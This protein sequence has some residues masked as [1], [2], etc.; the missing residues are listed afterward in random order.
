MLFTAI[1]L[2]GWFFIG[3]KRK[4]IN[5]NNSQKEDIIE[6]YGI[7]GIKCSDVVSFEQIS[8]N[9]NY[10]NVLKINKSKSIEKILNSNSHIEKT[11]KLNIIGFPYPNN[12]FMPYHT[13]ECCCFFDNK[14]YYLSVFNNGTDY[15]KEINDF[16]WDLYY[17]R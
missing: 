4:S 2:T 14:Y 3:G 13:E 16:F 11:E 12:K 5:L 9:R 7:N 1:Y 10:A 8:Y 15:N 17:Q 6:K